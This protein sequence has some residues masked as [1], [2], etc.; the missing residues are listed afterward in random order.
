MSLEDRIGY[1]FRNRRLLELALTH[2]SAGSASDGSYERLEFL[3]DRVLGLVIADLL[4]KRFPGEPEGHL[5]RRLNALVRKEALAEV[6]VALDLGS[7][8]KFGQSEEVDGADN[9]SI[10]SDVCEALIAAIY[11]DADLEAA[12][13]F[14]L[15]QWEARLDADPKPPRDAKSGL[16]EW[17]MARAL[18]FPTYEEIDRSG[19]DHAPV[20]TIRVSIPGHGEAVAEGRSKRQAEQSAAETLLER[21]NND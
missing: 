8:I 11:R 13:S 9:P 12:R 17:S 2:R 20:F 10:L 3:G 16:Q 4:L 1:Q 14:I 21:L 19:P 15:R 7:E 5:S 6:A 18:G